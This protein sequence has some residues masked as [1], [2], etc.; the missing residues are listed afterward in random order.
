[1]SLSLLLYREA[2]SPPLFIRAFTPAM[3]TEA[4]VEP[5][6]QSDVDGL[7]GGINGLIVGQH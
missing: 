3:W 1:M 4:R 5:E 6:R 2:I 7:R